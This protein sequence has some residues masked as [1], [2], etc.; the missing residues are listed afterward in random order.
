[1]SLFAVA[2][3]L[4]CQVCLV[5]G[6]LMLKHGMA[7]TEDSPRHWPRISLWL[8]GGIA[9]LTLWF[10]LWLGL[11]RTWDVSQL[12]PFEG[13]SPVLLVL[14]AW[15]LLGERVQERGWIGIVLIG[16]GVGLLAKP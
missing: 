5:A 3:C 1:M 11:L 16:L 15:I 9:S 10:F 13:L 14:S 6:N 4:L 2:V 7:A 8:A 12:Y